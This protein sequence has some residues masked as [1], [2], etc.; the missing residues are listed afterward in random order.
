MIAA[1]NETKDALRSGGARQMSNSVR[2]T[3]EF[4]QESREQYEDFAGT[5][6]CDV[7]SPCG[8][9]REKLHGLIDDVI[10]LPRELPFF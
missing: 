9:Y 4:L 2:S 7:D 1:M 10:A 5:N 8:Y 3:L 6:D